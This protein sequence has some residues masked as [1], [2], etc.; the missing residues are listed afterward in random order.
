MFNKSVIEVLSN[1]LRRFGWE[2]FE[3][4]EE[5]GEKE[6]MIKTGWAELSGEVHGLLIDPMIEKHLLG[7]RAI[8]VAKAPADSTPA[9][10]LNGLLLAIAAFNYQLVVG[11]WAYDPRDG[12]VVYRLGVPLNDG[13][14]YE[15]FEECLN[16]VR[17]AV[18]SQGP[19]L[20]KIIDGTATGQETVEAAH[21]PVGAL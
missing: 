12:E 7:F 15:D 5:Q 10:R 14:E 20:K 8:Q 9:D 2:N 17:T 3:V 11:G 6:G 19:K 13:V 21:L 1:H 18:E 4:V 16:V